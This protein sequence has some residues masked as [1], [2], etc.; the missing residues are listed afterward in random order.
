MSQQRAGGNPPPGDDPNRSI[1][2]AR[3]RRGPFWV[4]E[5][6]WF[7]VLASLTFLLGLALFLVAVGFDRP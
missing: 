1:A 6:G 7:W 4:E 5:P 3:Q 2:G